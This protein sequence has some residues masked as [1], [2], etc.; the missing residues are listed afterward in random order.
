MSE[1]E[2]K[3]T[4]NQVIKVFGL[5]TV[6]SGVYGVSYQKGMIIEM[7]IGNLNGNYD[8]REIFNS[9]IFGYM[10][11]YDKISKIN[12]LSFAISNW[13]LI[14]PF[15]VIGLIVP[16]IYNNRKYLIKSTVS[17]KNNFKSKLF[18][19]M[20]SYWLCTLLG[21]LIG[22]I[23]NIVGVFLTVLVFSILGALLLPALLGYM[24]GAAKITSVKGTEVCKS[25]SEEMLDNEYIRQCTQISIK[26]KTIMGEILLENSS[27]YFIHHNKSFLYLSKNKDV[28]IY[29]KYEESKS[30]KEVDKF[31]F[32]KS[33]LDEICKVNKSSS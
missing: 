12:I 17:I 21:T 2:N 1:K 7:G 5:I 6:I 26:G 11:L 4:L 27:G 3:F 29:S 25:I 13:K 33:Q 23:I 19:R 8:I 24:S 15:T 30:I 16:I 14:I 20:E 10:D 9:A 32:D 31:N 22:A 28:C 18:R